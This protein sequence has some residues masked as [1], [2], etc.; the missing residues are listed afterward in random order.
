MEIV[1]YVDI[2]LGSSL[3]DLGSPPLRSASL[4]SIS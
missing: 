1:K 4:A 3:F 2:A